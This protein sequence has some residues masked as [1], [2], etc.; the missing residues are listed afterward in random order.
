MLRS[1]LSVIAGNIVWTILWLAM[2]AILASIYPQ[3]LDG[4][5]RVE[6]VSLLSFLLVYS[7]VISVVAGYITALIARRNEIGH[8]FA[9]GILQLALGILFQSQAWNLLPVWYHLTFL[10]LLIPG[11]LFGAV[12]RQ[13][14]MANAV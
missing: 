6:S 2:N 9:L 12:L 1:I 5:T 3:T 14:Q 4:K 11:N 13:K 8:A 10:L 7:V